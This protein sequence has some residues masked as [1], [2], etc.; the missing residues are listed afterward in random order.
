[1]LDQQMPADQVPDALLLMTAGCSHCPAA[2]QSLTLLLKEGAIGRLEIVNVAIHTDEAE[3]R[4]VKSVPWVQ[5]GPFEVEGVSSPGK[6]RE[7]AA[8]VNDDAVFDTWLLETLKTGQRQKFESLVRREPHRIHALAR[9]MRNPET[10]MAIR[11]GIGA[12]LEELHGTGLTEPLIPALGEML[13]SDD[14]LLR[15]DACHFLTLIGGEAIRPW[16]RNALND[17]DPEIREIAQE[18]LG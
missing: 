5:I 9:L 3:S 18:G 4:G 1:M 10:S 7:L 8:G 6:L 16:L 13:K 14:R 2:L 17:P 12:I 15:A 11:L